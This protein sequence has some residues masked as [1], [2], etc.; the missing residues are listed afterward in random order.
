MLI[1]AVERKLLTK[2]PTEKIGRLVNNRR[3]I[4]IITLEE[5]KTLF[6]S[7]WRR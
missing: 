3:E 7:D 5:F 4:K 2:D 1:E 6:V